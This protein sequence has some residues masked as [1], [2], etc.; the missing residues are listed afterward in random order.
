MRFNPDPSKQVQEVIF[1]LKIKK[2]SHPVL[3]FNN[4]QVIQNPYQNHLGLF[5]DET[6]ISDEHLRYIAN[7]VNAS[8]G[9]LR[10]LQKCLSRRS[11]V[12]LYKSF[13]RPHLD[14]EDVILYLNHSMKSYNL[15]SITLH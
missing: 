12:T 7:K 3:S 9:L 2:P 14:Y 13:I 15:F 4:N 10:K 6:L 5:L 11:L 8:I 1:S